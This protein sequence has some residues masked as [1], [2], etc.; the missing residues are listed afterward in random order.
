MKENNIISQK[1]AINACNLLKDN[2]NTRIPKEDI[3][4]LLYKLMQ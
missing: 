4:N 1:E 3:E 2:S